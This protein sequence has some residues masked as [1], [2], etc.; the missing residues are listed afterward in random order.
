MELMLAE[1]RRRAEE[2]AKKILSKAKKEA[3]E[4][5]AR[6]EEEAKRAQMTVV[7]PEVSIIRKRVTGAASLRA[8]EI[9]MRTRE[10][11]FSKIFEAAKER[12]SKIAR[13]EDQSHDYREIMMELVEEAARKMNEK[14]LIVVMN[15]RDRKAFKG[16][17][18]EMERRLKKSL[19]YDVKLRLSD[20]THDDI[21][22]V[23]IYNVDKTKT[24]YNTLS[25][26]LLKLHERLR[27][28]LNK[29]LFEG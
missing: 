24:F 20:E 15:E 11:I 10:E 12:L 13:G 6:A 4:I 26:R 3:E 22:G 18:R 29:I 9:I 25:G 8:R 5:I 1:I 21:G 2:E 19:G 23:I 16:K 14:E 28:K 7:K 27:Y 17:I